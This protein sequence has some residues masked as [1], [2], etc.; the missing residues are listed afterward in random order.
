MHFPLFQRK[1]AILNLDMIRTQIDRDPR[2]LRD[3]IGR[4]FNA[5]KQP[6]CNIEKNFTNQRG[7][8]S[9]KDEKSF[10]RKGT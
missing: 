9:L 8:F 6:Y 7:N 10:S 4:W 2:P 5:D 1:N 3:C